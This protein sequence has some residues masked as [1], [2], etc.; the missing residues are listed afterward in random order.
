MA[1]VLFRAELDILYGG[2]YA[3]FGGL[4]GSRSTGT[5]L[6]QYGPLGAV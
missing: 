1:E 3:A 6:E 5:C 4:S 2:A